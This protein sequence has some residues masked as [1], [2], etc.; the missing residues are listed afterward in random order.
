MR[1]GSQLPAI[2]DLQELEYLDLDFGSLHSLV[3]QRVKLPQLKCLFLYNYALKVQAGQVH[4]FDQNSTSAAGQGQASDYKISNVE[5][6][7]LIVITCKWTV[8]VEL[9][10]IF[11]TDFTGA[12]KKLS[13]YIGNVYGNCTKCQNAET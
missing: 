7:A 10:K 12:D 11:A 5:P 4:L 13:L 2:D 6:I 1:D 8:L 9:G 3:R